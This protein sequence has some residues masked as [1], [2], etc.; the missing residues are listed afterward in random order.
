MMDNKTKQIPMSRPDITESDI[1][2]VT[3][4]LRSGQ[5]SIGPFIE[6]FED[7]A[8]TYFGTRYAVAVANGT[9]GL[10]LCMRLAGVHDGSEV[11][12]SPFSFVAST[13]CILYERGTPVFVDI[14]EATM[15]IDPAK[16]EHAVSERTVGILPIHVFGRPAAMDELCA[17]ADRHSLTLIEDACE[18]IGAE[19]RNRKVGTFG[20][21]SVF[22]FYPNKQLT[23]GEGAIVTTDD[24]DWDAGLRTLRNHGRDVMGA[25]LKH[26]R[27]G[28]NYRLNEMSAAL[29]V[30]QISRIDSL[31]DRRAAVAAMYSER[32]SRVP[33]VQILEPVAGTT[34]MSR[35]VYIV[36]FDPRL[37]R[38]DISARMAARGIPTRNYFPPIHLQP[39]FRDQFGFRQG[40]FPVTERVSATTIALPF[41]ANLSEPEIERVCSAL[42]EAIDATTRT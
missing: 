16:V 32:L 20:R 13:N 24:P 33:G 35:F 29:G 3:Q 40:Q 18:A 1:E 11:I 12:T 27:L 28:F 7:L 10:H 9:S 30:S 38:D 5:L 34:R 8:R 17:I 22:A 21:A 37:R 41:H 14:D 19:Y 15:N 2:L 6:K 39:Y 31:L 23:T 4:V 36:R 26:E 25:W 42:S